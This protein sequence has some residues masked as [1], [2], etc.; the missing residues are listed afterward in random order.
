ME[1]FLPFSMSLIQEKRDHQ[2][3]DRSSPLNLYFIPYEQKGYQE[4]GY[5]NGSDSCSTFLYVLSLGVVLLF[6]MM[7]VFSCAMPFKFSKGINTAYNCVFSAGV[8]VANDS[9]KF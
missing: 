3:G 5:G 1:V 4:V 2:H 7:A 9:P 8:I 6:F